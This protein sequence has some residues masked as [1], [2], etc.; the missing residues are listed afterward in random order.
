MSVTSAGMRTPIL[1]GGRSCLTVWLWCLW[2]STGLWPPLSPLSPIAYNNSTEKQC[3]NDSTEEQHGTPNRYDMTE[4]EPINPRATLDA[5]KSLQLPSPHIRSVVTD[6]EDLALSPQ[7][8]CADQTSPCGEGRRQ[9]RRV[10]LVLYPSSK[11]NSPC[12][13]HGSPS[14]FIPVLPLC[15]SFA[16][17]P[18]C[19]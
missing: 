8:M 18:C 13:M 3:T 17:G 6:V 10:P 9:I 2:N 14:C 1:C 16:H 11:P 5:I 7:T 12:I 19:S 4:D 15:L